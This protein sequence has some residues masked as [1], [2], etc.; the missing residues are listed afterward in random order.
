MQNTDFPKNSFAAHIRQL[1]SPVPENEDERIM[2]AIIE[3][4]DKTQGQFDSTTSFL[5]LVAKMIHRR[6]EFTRVSIGL[7]DRSD[8][9]F[10][11][12]VVIGF[13]G[14]AEQ[15]HKKRVYSLNDMM[16][17]I[18]FPAL[19]LGRHTEF[20]MESQA[21]GERELCNRPSELGKD[22]SSFDQLK[23]GELF[24]VFMYGDKHELIGWLELSGTKKDMLPTRK[25]IKWIELIAKIVSR[26][27]WERDYTH[28]SAHK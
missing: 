12:K 18:K 9:M 14:S 10:R 8:G 20:L 13:T 7:K 6:F 3:L 26:V 15:A 27:V 28:R 19:K 21:N 1:Y 5:D 2:V 4:L 17:D 25:T 22:R 16:D 23:E 24:D 11:Y